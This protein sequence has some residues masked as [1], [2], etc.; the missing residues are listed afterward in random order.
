MA[1]LVFIPG[2]V[3]FVEEYD[4][5]A[6]LLLVRTSGWGIRNNVFTLLVSVSVFR[7]RVSVVVLF[8]MAATVPSTDP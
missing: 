3:G 2:P 8:P 1:V 5:F 4:V 7:S 6:G